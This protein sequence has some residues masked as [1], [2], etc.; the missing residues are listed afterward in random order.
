MSGR[1]AMTLQ[2]VWIY[3]FTKNYA[4]P[5]F[6]WGIAAFTVSEEE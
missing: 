5:D 4:P 2:G 3:N 1:G 6:E